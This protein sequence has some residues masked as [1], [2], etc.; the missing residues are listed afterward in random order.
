MQHSWVKSFWTVLKGTESARLFLAGAA[1]LLLSTN[2]WATITLEPANGGSLSPRT[3]GGGG[4]FYYFVSAPGTPAVV[5]PAFAPFTPLDVSVVPETDSSALANQFEVNLTSNA[6]FSGIG[7]GQAVITVNAVAQNQDSTVRPAPIASVNGTRCNDTLCAAYNQVPGTNAYYAAKYSP[8]VNRKIRIGFYPAAACSAFAR[9]PGATAIYPIGCTQSGTASTINL[10]EAGTPTT[11]QF[12]FNILTSANSGALTVPSSSS[13]D[14]TSS[15]MTFTFQ[16]D[17]PTFGCPDRGTVLTSYSPGDGS[18]SFNGE[19][20]GLATAPGAAPSQNIFVVAKEGAEPDLGAG[21]R[22]T[23]DVASPLPLLA[24]WR[25]V[26]GFKNSMPGE[27][28]QYNVSFMITDRAGI[29][30]PAP[31][32]CGITG[33]QAATIQGYL[34]KSNCF[35]ATAAFDD[36][37]A[38]PVQILRVFRDGILLKNPIGKGLVRWYYSWSPEAADWLSE[39][40]LLRIPVLFALIPFEILAWVAGSPLSITLFGIAA[41]LLLWAA[42]SR[43]RRSRGMAGRMAGR[44]E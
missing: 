27:A 33:V 3:E 5:G 42:V 43:F 40:P 14:K 10:P 20:F 25:R 30:V 37:K 18:I 23:N 8:A 21:F 39:R 13:L 32:G 38:I 11:M 34:G 15:A 41:A 9:V 28:H 12:H 19:G 31:Q 22:S 16:V 44:I 6:S 24:A 1:G 26:D 4:N 17:T 29:Y 36:P 2:A 35:I 7:T